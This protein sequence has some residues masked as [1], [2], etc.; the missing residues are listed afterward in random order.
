MTQQK[1]ASSDSQHPTTLQTKTWHVELFS[2]KCGFQFIAQNPFE[3]LSLL[4]LRA[5][6]LVAL[7]SVFCTLGHDRTWRNATQSRQTGSHCYCSCR[8]QTWFL[9]SNHW[10]ICNCSFLTWIKFRPACRRHMASSLTSHDIDVL[11]VSRCTRTCQDMPRIHVST[12][13]RVSFIQFHSISTSILAQLAGQRSTMV[14]HAPASDLHRSKRS[15]PRIVAR[16]A[17]PV[18]RWMHPAPA[19]PGSQLGHRVPV[20]SPQ[21][22]DIMGKWWGYYMKISNENTKVIHIYIYICVCVCKH[23]YVCV[24]VCRYVSAYVRGMYVCM[25]VCM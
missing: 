6:V 10:R 25:C 14:D 11:E 9:S 8:L 24:Y 16:P 22:G 7:F 15:H 1:S 5:I 23:V 2:D 17:P 19:K 21:L 13:R 20:P 4:L 12:P 18:G 3:K